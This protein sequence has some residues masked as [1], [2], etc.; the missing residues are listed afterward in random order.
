MGLSPDLVIIKLCQLV[1]KKKLHLGMFN[2]IDKAADAYEEASFKYYGEFANP[3]R[4]GPKTG[5]R[6]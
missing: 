3:Q 5:F 1:N 6:E 4:G 2:D